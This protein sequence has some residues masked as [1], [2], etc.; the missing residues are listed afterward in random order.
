MDDAKASRFVAHMGNAP[1]LIDGKWCQ[2]AI[3]DREDTRPGWCSATQK[4][5]PVTVKFA[6]ITWIR[7]TALPDLFDRPC[8]AQ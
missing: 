5:T 1:L 2:L 3:A 8:M 7:I 6:P 4:K